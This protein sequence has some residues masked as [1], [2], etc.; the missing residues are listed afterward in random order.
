MRG[1]RVF[2]ARDAAV[3][4][5][6]PLARRNA[7]RR[8]SAAAPRGRRRRQR[9]RRAARGRRTARRRAAT[10]YSRD[11]LLPLA[12]AY[13]HVLSRLTSTHVRRP[14][15]RSL[16]QLRLFFATDSND[17]DKVVLRVGKAALLY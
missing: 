14:P 2:R 9:T 11:G 4:C 12:P 7:L 16:P 13:C 10:R 8:R 17:E 3:V 6:G 5:L 15:P 1:A